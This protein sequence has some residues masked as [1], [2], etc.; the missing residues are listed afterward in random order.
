MWAR[1]FPRR[2]PNGWIKPLGD[3]R[4]DFGRYRDEGLNPHQRKAQ[5]PVK[6]GPE[7]MAERVKLFFQDELG[8]KAYAAAGLPPAKQTQWER[9]TDQFRATWTNIGLA[10]ARHALQA[11]YAEMGN[12]AGKR[13]IRQFALSMG[14]ELA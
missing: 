14:I 6:E 12:D 4:D 8:R 11:A 9:G 3:V 5:P 2:A 13:E 7:V 10:S 1:S